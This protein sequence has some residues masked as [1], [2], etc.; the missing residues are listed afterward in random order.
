MKTISDKAF[1]RDIEH[2]LAQPPEDPIRITRKG[3]DLVAMS[4]KAY[5]RLMRLKKAFA[6]KAPSIKLIKPPT[7]KR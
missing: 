1:E 3:G 6:P 7:A 5:R 4:P 2:Y